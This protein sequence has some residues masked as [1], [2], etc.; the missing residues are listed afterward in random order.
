[1][2]SLRSLLL[3]F[4]LLAGVPGFFGVNAF[5]LVEYLRAFSS[6]SYPLLIR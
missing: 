6:L 4:T 3:R 1:M 5:N 2:R